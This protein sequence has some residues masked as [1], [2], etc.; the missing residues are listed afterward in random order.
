MDAAMSAAVSGLQAQSAALSTVSNNLANSSTTGYKAVVTEFNSL[1]TQEAVGIAYPAGGVQAVAAQNLLAQGLVQS[2]TSTTDMAIEGNGMFPVTYGL[3]ASAS[4]S[5][6]NTTTNNAQGAEMF[7]TRDGAFTSDA[8]GNLYLSGTNY[9]LAGWPTDTKGNV[10]VA[11]SD[12]TASLQPININK[13][14]SSA[15]ATTAYALQANLPAEAQSDVTDVPYTNTSGSTENVTMAYSLQSTTAATSTNDGTATYLLSIN[16]PSG[17]T[18]SDGTTTGSQLVYQVT[19]DTTG[20]NNGTIIGIEGATPGAAA[21][22]ALVGSTTNAL[23]STATGVALPALTPSDVGGTAF[24]YP[25]SWGGTASATPTTTWSEIS[26]SLTSTF[27][28]STSM[29]VYD[30]LGVEQSFP[31]TWTAAGDDTWLMTVGTPTNPAG[32]STTGSL[33]DSG[34]N[35]VSAY[36]YAVTFNTNGTLSAVTPL[37]TN[38]LPASSS[39]T[40]N[41]APLNTSGL[42]LLSA[43]WKD[44]A[45]AN[46]VTANSA[47]NLN[48]GTDGKTDGL[49]Q[50]DTGE[51]TPAIAVK[52]TTQNGVQYGQL[53][54]VTVNTAGEVIAAYDNGQ[55]VPI[56]KIPV[57]TFPNENG[58]TAMTDD[59]YQQSSLSGTYTLNPAGTNGAGTIEG[60]SL[61]ASTVDTS[62]EFA[63]MITAQQAY[64]SSSQVIGVDKQLFTTLLQSVGA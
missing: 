63:N 33:V 60:E 51:S 5:T 17:Q 32:T 40:P 48:L 1:L 20:S 35:T 43:T 8:Q 62:T 42:P 49:S 9:Y 21:Q 46:T 19:V 38:S 11:N 31:I 4:S 24:T 12:N 55:K 14:N 39:T 10:L 50:F 57:V 56:Y 30:S 18:I 36:T 34:G 15:V 52:S 16:A 25:S 28:Q 59:V 45:G 29:S 22:M 61:E 44:G 58:L 6:T 54:G 53:T 47:I 37:P 7:Y 23:G 26:T 41:E 27:S 2:T 13:Y 3:P 64:S